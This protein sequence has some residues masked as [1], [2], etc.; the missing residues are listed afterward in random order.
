MERLGQRLDLRH[1]ERPG[2]GHW[3]VLRDSVRCRFGAM[4][5][6]ER[7]VDVNIAQR[8]HL[9]RESVVVFLLAVVEA[10]ILEQHRLARLNCHPIQPV[11][12][13]GNFLAK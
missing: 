5:G 11:A 3:R 10:A 13:E 7:V 4:G 9:P 8:R 2:A 1:H 12:P 6:T